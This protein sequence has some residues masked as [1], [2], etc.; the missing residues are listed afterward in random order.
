MRGKRLLYVDQWGNRFSASTV[1]ELRAKVG[2]GRVS[3]MFQDK[4]DGSTVQT[5]YVVGRHWLTAFVPLELP[6]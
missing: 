1:R 4:K 6:A 2:G 5:G 3:R